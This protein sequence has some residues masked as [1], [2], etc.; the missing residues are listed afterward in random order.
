MSSGMPAR[1]WGI[2]SLIAVISA[3]FGSTCKAMRVTTV[4]RS[5][6]TGHGGG[7]HRHGKGGG[8]VRGCE[9]GLGAGQLGDQAARR[10]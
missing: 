10:S 3:V 7:D 2:G 4:P 8:F 6:G 9:A 1:I 5:K